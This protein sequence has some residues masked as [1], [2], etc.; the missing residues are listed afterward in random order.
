MQFAFT[1]I[2]AINGVAGVIGIVHFVSSDN[3]MTNADRLGLSGCI[4]QIFG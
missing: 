4:V 3:L 1:K 2:A